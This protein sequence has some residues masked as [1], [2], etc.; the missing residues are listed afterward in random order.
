MEVAGL[1]GSRATCGRLSVGAVIAKEGRIIVTGYNGPAAGEPHCNSDVCDESKPC[2]RSTHAEANAIKYAHERFMY[3]GGCTIYVTHS[4]C[5]DCAEKII[6]AGIKEVV[7]QELFRS[8]L[9]IN[10]LKEKGIN[11]RQW[12]T[13]TTK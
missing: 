7:Y 5:I 9:G 1:F 12:D 4:P 11:V 13:R 2:T 6:K 8:D 3:I 10:K